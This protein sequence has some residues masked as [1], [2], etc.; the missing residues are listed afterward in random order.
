MRILL[1]VTLTA[2]SRIAGA[3]SVTI[4][5]TDARGLQRE[6]DGL[7]PGDT[8]TLRAGEYDLT[9]VAALPNHAVTVRTRGVTIRGEEGAVLAGPPF[10]GRI[11]TFGLLLSG[12]DSVTLEGL[13]FT[14]FATAVVVGWV[15]SGAPRSRGLYD[16]VEER[17]FSFMPNGLG[18]ADGATVKGCTFHGALDAIDVVSADGFTARDNVISD[19]EFGITVV[20]DL[21]GVGPSPIVLADNDIDRAIWTGL[22]VQGVWDAPIS[23]T[24]NTVTRLVNRATAKFAAIRVRDAQA[25]VTIDGNVL[26]GV[27]RGFLGHNNADLRFTNNEV[28]RSRCS[29]VVIVLFPL[30][31]AFVPASRAV[32]TGNTIE[33]SGGAAILESGY[34]DPAVLV[35]EPNSMTGNH[36]D[37]VRSEPEFGAVVDEDTCD[38]LPPG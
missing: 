21:G 23:I 2:V 28:S 29:A 9:T 13:T 22:H 27:T 30:L 24:G 36:P 4:D 10:D 25:T 26:D 19:V 6:I 34:V 11:W 17:D 12:A 18:A 32:I 20:G 3:E 37:G 33:L 8:L 35:A 14:G 16:I 5:P 15:P 1:L 31:R 38:D 7:R